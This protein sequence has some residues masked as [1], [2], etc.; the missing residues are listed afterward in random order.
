MVT[1]ATPAIH[2]TQF[3]SWSNAAQCNSIQLT[4]LNANQSP[5]CNNI[6]FTCFTIFICRSVPALALSHMDGQSYITEEFDLK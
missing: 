1:H 6:S 5:K 2:A 3:N 4:Q